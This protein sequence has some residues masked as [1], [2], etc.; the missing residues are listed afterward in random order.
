MI[1]YCCC[2]YC[3][4]LTMLQDGRDRGVASPEARRLKG[5]KGGVGDGGEAQRGARHP[6]DVIEA[7][8]LLVTRGYTKMTNTCQRAKVM[9]GSWQWALKVCMIWW[10]MCFM[11]MQIFMTENNVFSYIHLCYVMTALHI[12]NTKYKPFVTVTS[13]CKW[14]KVGK[15]RK[16]EKQKTKT[17][18]NQDNIFRPKEEVGKRQTDRQTDGQR[19]KQMDRQRQDKTGIW[20]TKNQLSL[21]TISLRH[22]VVVLCSTHINCV[23]KGRCTSPVDA[24]KNLFFYVCV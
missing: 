8:R 11:E 4:L 20:V 15:K 6:G 14:N 1:V 22:L 2:C 21:A 13:I 10:G 12:R 9:K 16:R 17:S 7:A 23:G 5:L 24:H 19:D 18:P 3:F